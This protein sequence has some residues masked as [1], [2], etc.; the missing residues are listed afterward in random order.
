[1]VT[2]LELFRLSTQRLNSLSS[3]ILGRM[4]ERASR[5]CTRALIK[6]YQTSHTLR[7]TR[8]GHDSRRRSALPV[9]AVSSNWQY[10]PRFL[11]TALMW[12]AVLWKRR[13][14]EAVRFQVAGVT[15]FEAALAVA[16]AARFFFMICSRERPIS[17]SSTRRS[18][19]LIHSGRFMILRNSA[20]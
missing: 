18:M 17:D 14:G 10:M 19:P 9:L 3:I 13:R 12:A 4:T 1:M 20:R 7:F 8:E 16:R 2:M 6:R 5:G 11:K 15:G